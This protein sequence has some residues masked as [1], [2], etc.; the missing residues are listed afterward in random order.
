MAA[1]IDYRE[2]PPAA[3]LRPYV[4]CLWSMVGSGADPQTHRVLPDG[5]VD[6]LC[7]SPGIGRAPT[8]E[9]VGTMT[10]SL[11]V[12]MDPAAEIVAV[13]FLPGGAF[14]FLG[15]PLHELTDGTATLG[16][17]WSISE[18]SEGLHREPA[19][20]GRVRVLEHALLRRLGAGLRSVDPVIR[21]VLARLVRRP[22][23]ASIREWSDRAGISRQHLTR[24][25]REYT[26]VG[27]KELA[28]VLRLQ[29]VL[30]LVSRGGAE[31]PQARGWAFAA[32]SAGYF[33][34]SHLIAEFRSLAGTTP[35]RFLAER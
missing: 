21:D 2:Y 28:R 17:F 34:Q 13:R 30:D 15:L 5:C 20:R 23:D 11:E 4:S 6:I 25:V 14:P 3:P 33:D 27:P 7:R 26:G 8:L 16:E 31:S 32:V 12:S 1:G 24:R 22:A 9:V 19:T 18:L 35:A 29:G 10:R